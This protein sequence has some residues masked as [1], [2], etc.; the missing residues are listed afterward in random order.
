M[1]AIVHIREQWTST[2]R[3]VLLGLLLLIP[4]TPHATEVV[5]CVEDSGAVNIEQAEDGECTERI[6]LHAETKPEAV[7]AATAEHCADC[8]DVPLRV[9]EADDPCGGAVLAP[10][11][12]L[13]MPRED[14]VVV[15]VALGTSP[16]LDRDA[17]SLSFQ[18]HARSVRP[19][20][21]R[22][23]SLGSVVLLI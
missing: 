13:E 20:A 18:Q 22:D 21:D 9:S 6:R 14:G 7:E 11:L 2:L 1:H 23:A 4:A 16:V 17:T 12:E 15:S 8:A 5:L 10:S 3:V 19:N